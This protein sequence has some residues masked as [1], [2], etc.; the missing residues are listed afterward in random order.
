M[1]V[2]TRK[3]GEVVNIGENIVVT[4]IGVSSNRVQLAFEA[5]RAVTIHRGEIFNRIQLKAPHLYKKERHFGQLRNVVPA[6]L[7][8]RGEDRFEHQTTA[9]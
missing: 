4:V 7:F 2:L 3:I 9:P 8:R 1:L 5:P 6:G